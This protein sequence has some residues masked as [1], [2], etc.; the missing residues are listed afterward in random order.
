MIWF[1]HCYWPE[2]DQW[3]VLGLPKGQCA[4]TVLKNFSCGDRVLLALTRGADSEMRGNICWVCTLHYCFGTIARIVNPEVPPE[5]Y[6]RWPEA[7]TIDRLWKI[8]PLDYCSIANGKLAEEVQRQRGK[9][10]KIEYGQEELASWLASA[11]LQ[12]QH[13]APILQPDQYSADDHQR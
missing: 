8:E 5:R 1:K 11:T 9:L 13:R 10:F 12:E 4:K 3:G 6:Q 2:P 7:I